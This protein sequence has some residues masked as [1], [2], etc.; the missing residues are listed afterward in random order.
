MSIASNTI[1]SLVQS[2]GKID[3]TLKDAL[4]QIAS[5]LDRISTAVDPE[6]TISRRTRT[7]N[8]DAPPDV[9]V[10]TY[11][12]TTRNVIL[13]WESPSTDILLYEV[14]LGST[15]ATATRLFVTGN[16]SATLDP[17]AVGTTTYLI[18]AI[19][20]NGIYSITEDSVSVIIPALGSI[21]ITSQMIDN[22]VLLY[23]TEPVSTFVIDYYDVEKDG[24]SLGI[25]TGTFKAIWEMAGGIYTYSVTPYDIAGNQGPTSDLVLTVVDPPDY[26]LI[27]ELL[28][29]TLAGT[30][31][32]CIKENDYLLADVNITET[33]EGHF[34]S[35]GWASPQAQIDAGYPLH[36]QPSLLTGTYLKVLD[37]GSIS[38]N[39][40]INYSYS[41][42]IL[43][44]SFNIGFSTRVSD[45]NVSWSAAQTGGNIFVA[46]V[47]YIEVTVT[48]TAADDNDLIKFWN[49]QANLSQKEM[50][51]SGQVSA[52]SSDANGTVVTFNKSFNDI[53]SI[54]VSTKTTTE[55][56][57]VVYRFTDIPN[58]TQFS[59]FV[60]DTSG[61]RVSKTVD[62][63]ARGI[64]IG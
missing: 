60:Y 5:E 31:V 59:V 41:F 29:D 51:D 62:W 56:F 13:S 63:K 10:F 15:W 50:L 24:V 21:S 34:T 3:P 57:T 17:I 39:V 32:S 37:S 44:G 9:S 14:R 25:I 6:P 28:D 30:K 16:L 23:W 38:T 8:F 2:S 64:A 58:P 48:F 27:D 18:K 43:V 33:F 54:T 40:I 47:R 35:R 42:E 7:T 53:N 36:I 20:S 11:S 61:I 1:N 19:N 52:I 22:N 49:L 55:Q 46:S 45:D 26:V 12:L 4:V